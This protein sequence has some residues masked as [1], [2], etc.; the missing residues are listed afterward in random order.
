M[1]RVFAKGHGHHIAT[2]HGGKLNARHVLVQQ[3]DE[4]GAVWRAG[5][6]R[7]IKVS[8][9]DFQRTGYTDDQTG[10]IGPHAFDAGLVVK[11]RAKPLSGLCNDVSA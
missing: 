9:D 8:A 2:L 1:L 4:G 7:H 6:G 11:R 3:A 5:I 10:A